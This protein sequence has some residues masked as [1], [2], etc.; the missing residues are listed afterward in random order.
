MKGVKEAHLALS[1]WVMPQTSYYSDGS[2][3]GQASDIEFEGIEVFMLCVS[4]SLH[5]RHTGLAFTNAMVERTCIS[6]SILY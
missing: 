6:V 1:F 2:L 3:M 4:V 5:T